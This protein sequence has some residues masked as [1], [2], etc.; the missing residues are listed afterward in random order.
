MTG[1]LKPPHLAAEGL[2]SRFGFGD[3]GPF[4]F[5]DR[6][7]EHDDDPPHADWTLLREEMTQ[8][9]RADLLELLVRR[10]LLPEIA[11]ATGETPEIARIGTHHNPVRDAR[12][13]RDEGAMPPAWAGVGVEVAPD[14]VRAAA[15]EIIGRTRP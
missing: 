4:E 11:A 3:G 8:D 6:G 7:Q 12:L 9:Q 14:Q 15:A 13:A 5:E 10:H 2:W 1:P